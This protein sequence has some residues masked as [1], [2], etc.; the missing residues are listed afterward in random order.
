[1]QVLKGPS[2]DSL[3][4]KL[5]H[6]ELHHR[7]CILKNTRDIRGGTELSSFRARAEGSGVRST[8]SRKK[9]LAD[10][11]GPLL[12]TSP[13]RQAGTKSECSINTVCPAPPDLP[14]LPRLLP[15]NFHTS[16]LPQLV[17]HPSLKSLKCP[18]PPNKQWLTL[19]CLVPLAM[20]PK[21]CRHCSHSVCS[22]AFPGCLQ[23]QYR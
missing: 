4:H 19:A 18:Q 11:I 15:I 13:T 12:S 1:M 10:T 5:M 14:T 17:L 22:I 7:D 16:G 21:A 23:S 6:S 2:I 20:W 3:A 9:L 8:L